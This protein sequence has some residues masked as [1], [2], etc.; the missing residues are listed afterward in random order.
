MVEKGKRVSKHR[1]TDREHQH[2]AVEEHLQANHY[3]HM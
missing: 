3:L 2:E 1:P